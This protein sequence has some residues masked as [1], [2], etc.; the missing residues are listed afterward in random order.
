MCRSICSIFQQNR[1]T[2]YLIEA[3]NTSEPAFF[4]APDPAC[5]EAW[6]DTHAFEGS[7]EEPIS[8]PLWVAD[9]S[10][11]VARRRDLARPEHL[12]RR[13]LFSSP[14][15]PLDDDQLDPPVQLAAAGGE[16]GGNRPAV[17]EPDCFQTSG[18]DARLL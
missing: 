11:P 9:P 18:I 3:L 13:R 4:R 2:R 12:R 8:N 7:G 5:G 6:D 1:G 10:G 16:I 14:A 17:A 15:L